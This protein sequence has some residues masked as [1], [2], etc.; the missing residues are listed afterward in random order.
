MTLTQESVQQ[1]DDKEDRIQVNPVVYDEKMDE[2]MSLMSQ[3][4]KIDSL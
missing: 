1:T 4:S 3:G 2:V